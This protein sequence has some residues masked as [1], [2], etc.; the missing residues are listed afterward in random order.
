[1]NLLG[2]I[3]VTLC[4]LLTYLKGIVHENILQDVNGIQN[5]LFTNILQH[6]FVFCRRK[7]YRFGM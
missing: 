6:S 7:S 4:S 3:S 1:M 2:Y 5:C